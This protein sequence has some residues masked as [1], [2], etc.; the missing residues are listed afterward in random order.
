MGTR[1]NH[2]EEKQG[3]PGSGKSGDSLTGKQSVRSVHGGHKYELSVFCQENL[4][5]EVLFRKSLIKRVKHS[6][7]FQTLSSVL[8]EL[9]I[10]TTRLIMKSMANV[11]FSKMSEN[12]LTKHCFL[13]GGLML[14]EFSGWLRRGCPM[15]FS[16]SGSVV[17]PAKSYS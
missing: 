5:L 16:L 15:G 13:S 3:N 11:E 7:L 17:Y 10:K 1:S 4:V 12:M 14:A 8:P 9:Q 6:K 2:Q